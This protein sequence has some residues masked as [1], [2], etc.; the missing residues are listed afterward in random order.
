MSQSQILFVDFN[1]DV[2]A[3]EIQEDRWDEVYVIGDVHGCFNELKSLISDVINVSKDD[4]L[5]FVGDLIRKG[6]ESEKVV[7]YVM[8]N[9]NIKSVRGNNEEK[10]ISDY[11]IDMSCYNR[12]YNGSFNFDQEVIE[13]ISGLPYVISVGSNI[14]LHGGIKTHKNIEDNTRYDI[15]HSRSPDG[16]DGDMWYESYDGSRT[17]FFGH[18]VHDDILKTQNS[19]ALDTGC[20]YGGELSCVRILDG[21][22]YSVNSKGYRER[23]SDKIINAHTGQSVF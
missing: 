11:N 13:Y 12:P 1:T 15:L 16:Y 20:V 10:L 4:L 2:K 8:Q 18:T 9:S 17:I 7:K 5:L 21:K 6:P 19:V 22:V 14:V 23:D 3:E